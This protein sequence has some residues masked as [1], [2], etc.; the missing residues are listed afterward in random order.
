[1]TENLKLMY[2][3][4]EHTITVILDQNGFEPK[5][6]PALSKSLVLNHWN[7]QQVNED[8]KIEANDVEIIDHAYQRAEPNKYVVTIHWKFI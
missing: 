7:N 8:G 4:K 2:S 1:M 6:F 5:Q 3:G